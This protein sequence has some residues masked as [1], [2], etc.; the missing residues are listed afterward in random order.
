MSVWFAYMYICITDPL[1]L[2]LETVVSLHV[3][4]GSQTQVL[5]PLSHLSSL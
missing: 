1:R 4:T 2:E 5:K 3:G